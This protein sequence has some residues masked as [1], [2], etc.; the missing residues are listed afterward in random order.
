[1]NSVRNII[2]DNV[3]FSKATGGQANS[4]G[5]YLNACLNSVVKNCKGGNRFKGFHF[6]S[7]RDYTVFNNNLTG[8]GQS[9]SYP[10]LYFSSV[11]GQTIPLGIIAY[12]NTFGGSSVRTA[13]RVYNMKDLIVGDASVS[14][15]HI[16]LE[17]NS[18][19]N[20]K[21]RKGKALAGMLGLFVYNGILLIKTEPAPIQN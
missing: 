21:R 20:C 9:I 8:S 11:Q 16:V 19:V 2:I 17:D 13:L 3:D 10:G 6:N 7:G 4:F 15:A 14:G 12:G 5:L 1:M 18:G